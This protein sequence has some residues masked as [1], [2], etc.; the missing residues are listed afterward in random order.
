MILMNLSLIDADAE[1]LKVKKS[2][3]KLQ[4]E[5]LKKDDTKFYILMRILKGGGGV[6]NSFI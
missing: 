3:T 1:H 5:T 6:H 4:D 2:K